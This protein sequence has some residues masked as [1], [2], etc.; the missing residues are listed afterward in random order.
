[1]RYLLSKIIVGVGLCLLS[2]NEGACA[3]CGTHGQYMAPANVGGTA[4]PIVIASV[5]D[6]SGYYV[7]LKFS[8]PNPGCIENVWFLD[9]STMSIFLTAESTRKN[10]FVTYSSTVNSNTFYDA[11]PVNYKL[12]QANLVD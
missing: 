9:K 5:A 3:T 4:S 2:W 6:G 10:V 12:L 1:M 11:P 8:N 7:S